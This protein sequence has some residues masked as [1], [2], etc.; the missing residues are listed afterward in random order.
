M[1]RIWI[2]YLKYLTAQRYI[3]KTRRAFDQAL[4][5]LPV[6]QHHRIW[7]LYITFIKSHHIPE[8]TVRVYRRY[9]QLDFNAAEDYIEYLIEIG[10]LDDAAVKLAEVVNA[11][12]F[13]SKKGRT[14]HQLWQWLCELITK[15]PGSVTSLRVDPIIRGGLRRFTD[16]KGT[17]WCAL[18]DYYV[19]QG[20]FEKAR[21]VYVFSC[22]LASFVNNAQFT[23]SLTCHLPVAHI[24]THSHTCKYG[25]SHLH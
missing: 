2:D 20:N 8:T 22:P 19:R 5:S 15:N 25:Y 10:R 3:T 24:H 11:E 21:D 1:P 4:L 9:L 17:L 23:R 18:A 13:A 12:K 7:P 14:N 6:T 16:M